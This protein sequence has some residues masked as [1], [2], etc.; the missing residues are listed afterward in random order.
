MI[1]NGAKID[2]DKHDNVVSGDNALVYDSNN[3]IIDISDEKVA[4][5]QGLNGYII[6]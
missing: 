5:I 2:K 6:V 1:S 4:V 3:C